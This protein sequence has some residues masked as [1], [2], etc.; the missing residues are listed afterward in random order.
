MMRLEMLLRP[1]APYRSL[2]LLFLLG[3]S[4]AAHAID[5]LPFAD[6]AQEERFQHLTRELRC[7]VCQNQNLA[8]SDAGLAKD[9]RNEVFEQM[10]AGKSDA[11][12]RQYLVAR[13]SEFVLYD[14]PLSAHT[15]LLWFGPFALL[16]AGALALVFVVRRRSRAAATPAPAAAAPAGEEEDW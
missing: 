8:D 13:Y 7:L 1:G 14:P 12:I 2:M 6:A 4:F 15:L 16:A 11:E 10:R 5:P 9:L 3:V